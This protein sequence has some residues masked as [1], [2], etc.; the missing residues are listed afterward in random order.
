VG[1]VLLA[2]SVL[3][4]GALAMTAAADRRARAAAPR[5]QVLLLDDTQ[6]VSYALEDGELVLDFFGGNGRWACYARGALVSTGRVDDTPAFTVR[7][8]TDDLLDIALFEKLARWV[9]ASEPLQVKLEGTGGTPLEHPTH[10]QLTDGY[11]SLSV[12]EPHPS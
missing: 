8:A 3:V 12:V 10:L 2:T 4:V 11:R 9:E 7:A 1:P 5:Q 6:L